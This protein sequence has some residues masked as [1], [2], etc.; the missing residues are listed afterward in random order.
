MGIKIHNLLRDFISGITVAVVALP[1]AIGFGIT[2]GVSAAAGIATA[3]VAGFIVSIFGGSKF[4]ISG[5]TGAMTVVLIPIIQEFGVSILPAVGLLAGLILISLG[6]LRVGNLINKVPNE[7]IAGF[8]AGIAVII[9]LQQLP[10]AFGV[11]K[12]SGDRTLNVAW[13][14]IQNIFSEPLRLATI[15]VLALTLIVKFGLVKVIESIGL[16]SYIPASFAAILIST[17]FVQLFSIKVDRIGDI[18]RNVFVFNS[19]NFTKLEILIIPALS[20]ALLAAIESLLSAR[21]ADELANENTLKPNRELIG[22]GFGTL[23]ASVLGGMPATGAIA[24]TSVNVRSN[25]TSKW[26]GVFHAFTILMVILFLAPLFAKIPSA[27]IAGVLIG[28]SFRIFNKASFKE[29]LVLGKS[30]IAI[31]FSTAFA[32]IAIDL[33]WGIAIGVLFHLFI[34]RVRTK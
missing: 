9:A 22:Q 2:S 30:R 11:E 7:V 18:P 4:Q 27:A 15:F 21:V 1:L 26:S 33:I 34:S 14:T 5:P 25:A 20:I 19:P 29:I 3:I 17:A 32:T 16:K 10:L 31:Y 8:T 23:A 13:N 24:R 28:T 12:G 6:L